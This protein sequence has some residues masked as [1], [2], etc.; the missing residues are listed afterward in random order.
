MKKICLSIL[1]VCVAVFSNAQKTIINDANAERRIVS[2]FTAINVSSAV[3]LYLTQGDEDGIAVSAS[4][5]KYRDRIKTEV[6]DGTLKIWYDDKGFNWS[7]GNKKMRAYVSFKT[8][9]KLHASGASDVFVNGTL[10]ATD[11]DLELSGASDFKG[12]INVENLKAHISGASDIT[13]SGKVGSLIIDASGSSDF[14]GYDLVAQTCDA[15]AS[16]ASDIKITVDKELSASASGASDIRI[17]GNG[18]IKK[19]SNS[20][21]SSVKKI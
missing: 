12:D 14:K 5:T 13:A 15:E 18:V 11:L 17:K 4:E 16:G 10:K 21:A 19:M 2:G 1:M 6:K 20:G 3:D 7:T 8:L 9:S